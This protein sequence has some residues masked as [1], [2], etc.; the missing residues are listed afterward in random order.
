DPHPHHRAQPHLRVPEAPM[1]IWMFYAYV[2]PYLWAAQVVFVIAVG[3]LGWRS[4]VNEWPA[5]LQGPGAAR[6]SPIVAVVFA[7]LMAPVALMVALRRK[8][9][10]E[11]TSWAEWPGLACVAQALL[12]AAAG[13]NDVLVHRVR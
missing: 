13:V 11:P 5:A 1:A 6:L 8:D 7:V 4:A 12:L 10:A 2:G 3:A 9:R